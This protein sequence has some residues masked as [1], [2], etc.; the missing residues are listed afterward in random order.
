MPAPQEEPEAPPTET[1]TP[2][3]PEENQIVT[4]V[5]EEEE[6]PSQSTVTLLE[7]DEEEEEELEVPVERQRSEGRQQ[8]SLAYCRELSNVSCAASLHEYLHRWCSATLA[9]QRQR[10]NRQRRWEPRR[11]APDPPEPLPL[12]PTPAQEPPLDTERPLEAERPAPQGERIAPTD[13]AQAPSRHTEAE[14]ERTAEPLELEPSQTASLPPESFSS[15]TPTEEIPRLSVLEL[16]DQEVP[17]PNGVPETQAEAKRRPPASSSASTSSSSSPSLSSS[18]VSTTLEPAI[19]ETDAPKQDPPVLTVKEP[20]VQPLPTA[21]RPAEIPPPTE[22][23]A[24]PE[25]EGARTPPEEPARTAPAPEHPEA[26]VLPPEPKP[27]E[28]VED[29][30]LTVHSASAQLHRTATDFYAELQNSTDLSY[31]NGNG[32]QVHGS[33]QKESVFMRLNNRI[34]ALEMNMSLSSR[35][36]EELS[37]R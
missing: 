7:G 17:H 34:K 26:P 3:P 15:V 5:E 31:G 21:T 37:Q 19:P 12:V 18:T 10:S 33:N 22:L 32:N 8:E 25:A 14:V 6:E 16:L 36:L 13:V 35:Y 23:P 9:L 30:L 4:L 27:E 20:P 28:T 1:P 11:D 24:P 29:L 2:A